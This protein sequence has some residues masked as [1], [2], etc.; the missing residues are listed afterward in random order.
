MLNLDNTNGYLTHYAFAYL[1]GPWLGGA[2]AGVFHCIYIN[3]F[4]KP[5]IMDDNEAHH[6]SNSSKRRSQKINA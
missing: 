1:A 5:M 6:D 3:M 4:E 2:L